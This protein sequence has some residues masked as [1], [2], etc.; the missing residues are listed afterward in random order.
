MTNMDVGDADVAEAERFIG[1]WKGSAA[2]ELSTSQSFLIDLCE[3][4]GVDRPHA[5]AEQDYMFERPLTFQQRSAHGNDAPAEGQTRDDAILERLVALNA[6]RAA[7]EAR[8]HIRWLR[9]EFQNPQAT[10]APQQTELETRAT[11]D[12]D[13]APTA[14]PVGKPIA[15]P[16][17]AVEQ[18][19]TVADLLASSPVPLSLDEIGN[20]FT[21]RGPWK[22]RLPQ[23]VEMLVA[24]GRAEIREGG[25]VGAGR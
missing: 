21:A 20:R 12:E 4:L 3:L 9:L 11:P 1:K 13:T 16:K 17:D 23:L 6:E 14:I 25:V 10:N 18:V 2:S 24:L 7:E 5:T 8:G 19:R 15:W 22:K